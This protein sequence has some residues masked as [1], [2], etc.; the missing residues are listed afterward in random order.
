MTLPG[1]YDIQLRPEDSEV[2]QVKDIK[3]TYLVPRSLPN[4]HGVNGLV[5]HYG[6]GGTSTKQERIIPRFADTE[7]QI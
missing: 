3:I 4:L 6:K 5:F 2:K 7:W 1:D